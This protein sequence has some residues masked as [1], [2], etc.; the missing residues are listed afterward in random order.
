MN[1]SAE[2]EEIPV[3][4]INHDVFV[5]GVLN[6]EPKTNVTVI[7][8]N[9]KVFVLGFLEKGTILKWSITSQDGSI[10]LYIAEVAQYK[11]Y[12]DGMTWLPV[13]ENMSRTTH[14]HQFEI[15]LLTNWTLVLENPGEF[16]T[17]VFYDINIPID[18]PGLLVI[19]T[20]LGLLTI[21]IVRKKRR[22]E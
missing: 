19:P 21:L 6:E 17:L 22:H 3:N 8:K 16:D 20:L 4:Q 2:S 11:K 15:P 9:H 12:A 10:N 7:A 1:L 5:R 13:Y 18:I 14:A